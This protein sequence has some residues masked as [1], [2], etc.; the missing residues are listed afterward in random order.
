MTASPQ[1]DGILLTWNQF[2][3][4]SQSFGHFNIY[5]STTPIP[6]DVTGLTRSLGTWYRLRASDLDAAQR[7]AGEF[8]LADLAREDGELRFSADE[9]LLERFMITLGQRR[10]GVRALIP[11]QATLEQLFFQLTEQDAAPPAPPVLHAV[12]E[13]AV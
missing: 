4:G 9:E 10:I 13:E 7:V 8:G 5:R 6:G 1:P 12:A 11:Q 3:P 2:S